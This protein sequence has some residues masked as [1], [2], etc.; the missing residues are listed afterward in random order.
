MK[1]NILQNAIGLK[2]H[3]SRNLWHSWLVVLLDISLAIFAILIFF[4]RVPASVNSKLAKVFVVKLQKIF[5]LR[6]FCLEICFVLIYNTLYI[7]LI[8]YHKSLLKL[9]VNLSYNHYFLCEFSLI[10]SPL[11]CNCGLIIPRN[12]LLP[13]TI[14][15]N[16][17]LFTY[18]FILTLIILKMNINF[19]F[20]QHFYSIAK[21]FLTLL[22]GLKR[23][24]NERCK[25][26][27]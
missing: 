15:S 10:C 16:W 3:R 23:F 22:L 7:Y 5:H 18:R 17:K 26:Y 25:N 8:L 14:S 6:K 24:Y 13:A 11:E 19:C 12:F 1:A 9:D 2:N 4:A 21:F 27:R 20:S